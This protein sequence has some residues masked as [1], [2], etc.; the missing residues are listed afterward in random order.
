MDYGHPLRFGASLT[1]RD[2]ALGPAAEL[3]ELSEELGYD[4]VTFSSGPEPADTWTL[5]SWT[6][7]RTGRVRLLA[8][9][10]AEMNPAVTARAAA[11][12]D[13]LAKGR[14]ELVLA[15]RPSDGEAL[16]E[17][18][19]IVRGMWAAADRSPLSYNGEH[20]KVAGAERGP[21]PAHTIP[22]WIDGADP[23]LLRLAGRRADGWLAPPVTD[24]AGVGGLAMAQAA[25][26]AAAAERGRDPREIN[27]LARIAGR[28]TSD[29][30][31]FLTGPPGTWVAD[32]LPLVTDH[33]FAMF[34]L[35][36]DDPET[37]RRFAL[38]V[39]PA[40][41]AAVADAR[42][43][44]GV[45]ESAPGRSAL[46]RSKRREGIDYDAVPASLSATAV[47]PGDAGY[48]RVRSTYLRG[49]APGLVLRPGTPAEVADAIRFA[50]SQ[51]VQLG[52]RSGG[53][54][55]S[56][57]STNH[58]GI[59]ID[60]SRLHAIEVL[61]KDTRR[62]R[63]GPGARWSDVAEALAPHGWALSS[64][65]YGGVGVGGLATAGGIGWLVRKHG[66]TLDHLCAVEMVLA[67]G[68]L[69][70]ADEHENAELFWG[71]RGAGGNFGVVTSFEFE[72]DEVGD[73]GFAQ[74][75]FDATDM[76][77]FLQRW[78][79]AM[80]AAP[81]DLT[82]S[83]IMGRPRPG[84]PHV[85]QLMAVV[86]S[87]DGQTIIDRL[88]PI[89]AIAP[90]LDY[91]IQVLPYAAIMHVPP[92]THDAQG[93]PVTRAALADHLTPE[94]SAAAERLVGAGL[95]YFFQIRSVG[96]A[97]SDVPPEATAYAGRSA[98]FQ[99]VAMGHSRRALDPAWDAMLPHFSGQ[100]INFETD[101]RPE[102][103]REAYPGDT[104]RRLRALKRRYDPGNVFRDNFNIDPAEEDAVPATI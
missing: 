60:V 44:R 92:G 46:V 91:S 72:V 14:A 85:A 61:D 17:A 68:S 31:G 37:L 71:V 51:P 41:R 3:A 103:V 22:V 52:I 74:F 1:A 47:E 12:L 80:E 2:G 10:A 81:R 35:A 69:V 55:I 90:L 54:G 6:A 78:G 56:G 64:G 21:A 28:F 83:I 73:V 58:G 67:D 39:V 65:D 95:T 53:H 30:G 4:L 97:A 88:Q 70:R 8:A 82:S 27:R 93:E 36:G 75:V 89:A 84:Q 26:D 76:A 13:L 38:E 32:L 100:Y 25:I 96:G 16:G 40:L 15:G 104:L 59:V 11:S 99:L 102:R 23:A 86:D 20:H 42:R 77:G 49:G 94:L 34:V 79:A 5:M 63:I 33:G 18:I 9:H 29:P 87:D 48:A 66:L 43:E 57:R 24:A 101:R 45:T 50:S 62:V 19:E 98:N 7:A